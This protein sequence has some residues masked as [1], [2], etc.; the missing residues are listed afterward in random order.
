MGMIGGGPGAFIG[1][2]HRTAALMDGEIELVCGAF[3]SDPAKSK[4]S[5]QQLGLDKGRIYGRYEEMIL[6]EK[7]L[8]AA[9][10]MDFVSI[11]TPNHVH[12]APA[13]MALENGFHVVMDKPMTFNLEE[14]IELR[15]IVEKTGLFFLFNAYLYWL[16]HDQGSK[17]AGEEG[18]HR[19]SQENIC[20]LSAG[21]VK[22]FFRKPAGTKAG[23]M[24]NRSV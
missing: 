16:S 21:M 1:A 2:V 4:Q 10:R 17:R 6:S 22:F 14:A 5:G 3:S 8:P 7:E 18:S 23:I 13:K 12:F 24:E 19:E 15:S 11:V 20:E 9:E